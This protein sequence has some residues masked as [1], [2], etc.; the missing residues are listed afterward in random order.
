M[1]EAKQD[2]IECRQSL[3]Y[4]WIYRNYHTKQRSFC[5]EWVQSCYDVS[6]VFY[7]S[8][9]EERRETKED[10]DVLSQHD[11]YWKSLNLTEEDWLED[12][13]LWSLSQVFKCVQS[14]DDWEVAALKRRRHRSSNWTKKDEQ[15]RIKS[16]L[17]SSIQYNKR[18]TTSVA[19]D[20]NRT[21]E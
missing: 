19:K 20:I 4:D 9:T 3:S 12:Y 11:W 6:Y 21:F 13:T 16:T 18:G 5:W 15:K 2:H 1:N 7:K 10:W 8:H 14:Y 17:K